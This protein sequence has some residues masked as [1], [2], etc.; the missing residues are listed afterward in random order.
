MKFPEREPRNEPSMAQYNY[1]DHETVVQDDGSIA[2]FIFENHKR[3]KGWRFSCMIDEYGFR[4]WTEEDHQ[5]KWDDNTTFEQLLLE[6]KDPKPYQSA[7]DD[8][9]Y[10]FSVAEDE[11]L[12]AYVYGGIL[13]E[14]GGWFVVKKNDPNK[15]IRS[16]QTWM[17]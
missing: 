12:H 1:Y 11:E 16:T 13:S 14:R 10:D 9:G 8:F 4:I 2:K 15:I 7:R 6:S 3:D 5:H 17:S